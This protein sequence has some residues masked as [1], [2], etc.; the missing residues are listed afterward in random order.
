MWHE[1]HGRRPPS[2]KAP[3]LIQRIHDMVICESVSISQARVLSIITE[4]LVLKK[5]QVAKTILNL[6]LAEDVWM[7][8]LQIKVLMPSVTS[9][10]TSLIVWFPTPNLCL[11]L[12]KWWLHNHLRI[13]T[14][15][16][17]GL[18]PKSS[19]DYWSSVTTWGDNEHSLHQMTII[20]HHKWCQNPN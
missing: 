5:L 8:H 10:I 11:L 7:L 15:T 17:T 4:D 1:E 2:W 14:P 19:H 3:E 6:S 16:Y 12:P 9:S 20:R 18:S 13:T